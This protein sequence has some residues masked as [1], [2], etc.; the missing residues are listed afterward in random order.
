MKM[1][2]CVYMFRIN[3]SLCMEAREPEPVWSSQTR[4]GAHSTWTSGA[5]VFGVAGKRRINLTDRFGFEWGQANRLLQHSPS[6][7]LPRTSPPLSLISTRE[8]YL[9]PACYRENACDSEP[10]LGREQRRVPTKA[11]RQAVIL[12]N[13]LP[14]QG[15][16]KQKP[17]S[18]QIRGEQ[19]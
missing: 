10:H 9:H 16:Q 15:P 18:H 1:C 14:P 19:S 2:A 3:N 7:C 5:R 4:Y 17:R 6:C 12:H 8:D 13:S 11:L